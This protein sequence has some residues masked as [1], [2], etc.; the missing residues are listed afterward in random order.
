MADL[1]STA[2]DA[3]NVCNST[4]VILA[5]HTGV[6]QIRPVLSRHV[7]IARSVIQIPFRH[8]S[9]VLSEQISLWTADLA[10]WELR[11]WKIR[12]C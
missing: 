2:A 5:K 4:A 10:I 12:A 9:L 11:G 7:P 6:W 8:L 3:T 1:A